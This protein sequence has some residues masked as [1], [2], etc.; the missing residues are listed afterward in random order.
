MPA[1]K[2]SPKKVA[3]KKV[4]PAP[5]NGQPGSPE[6]WRLRI[7][8]H[9]Q[10]VGD[11]FLLTFRDGDN[12]TQI[13]IDCGVLPASPVEY[14]R[15]D[16]VV[17]LIGEE[18]KNNGGKIDVL[19][20]THEHADHVSAFDPAVKTAAV[21]KAI[22]TNEVWMAWTEDSD[23]ELAKKLGGNLSLHALAAASVVE[24]LDHVRKN[25]PKLAI[26]QRA[27]LAAGTINEVLAN[28]GMPV[29][30]D[31]RTIKELLF[32]SKSS[33]K[34][35]FAAKVAR[36]IRDAMNGAKG[37]AAEGKFRTFKP[38]SPPHSVPG[39]PKEKVRVYVL[40]PP[41]LDN[42]KK[43]P[44]S[45]PSE[46][47]FHFA[48]G[49]LPALAKSLAAAALPHDEM[50]NGCAPFS[51][52]WKLPGPGAGALADQK[53]AYKSDSWRT[54]DNDWLMSGSD[55]ALQLDSA[56]NNTSL[57]L[58][59]EFVETGEV[60]LFPG[61]AQIENWETWRDLSWTIRSDDGTSA[62]V[63]GEDLLRRTIFYKVGHHGSRNATL[64]EHGLQ[65]MPSAG[66]VA[67]VPV[68]HAVTEKRKGDWKMIPQP[69]LCAALEQRC[70]EG[71]LRMDAEA[72]T[73]AGR[74]GG[75]VQESPLY[76]DYYVI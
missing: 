29:D 10:G 49:E 27:E 48:A 70:G 40:G 61:D 60:M 72:G 34:E 9:R 38:G 11:C 71:F 69:S 30:L 58:A 74:L 21:L 13:L 64:N 24:R 17:D 8:M 41:R 68:I 45:G 47:I 14:N 42:L 4:A 22:P 6:D 66:L 52:K 31:S 51:D 75:R 20:I 59:F 39:I 32:G 57:V 36:T 7:R 18:I 54:I 15:L 56:T 63:T 19:V 44:R 46:D 23:D 67:M 73:L 3:A 2:G 53:I 50:T 76:V 25:Y 16:E 33:S 43:T 1:K 55:F 28:I 12:K 65:L 5:P 37:H 26:G 62:K 35:V